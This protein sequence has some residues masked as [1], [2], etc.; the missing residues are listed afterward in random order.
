[1]KGISFNTWVYSSF[2]NWLSSYPLEEVI[3]RLSSFGYD[4][5]EIGCLAHMHGR[6]I[7]Q[8]KE[9]KKSKNYSRKRT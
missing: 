1:M 6:I 2:P 4:A 7:C 3:N 5:I 8:L 9:D